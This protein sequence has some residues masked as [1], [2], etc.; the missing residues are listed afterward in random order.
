M[1]ALMA[2]T[3]GWWRRN[4][5]A[6]G[7]VAVLLPATVGGAAWWG[8]KHAYPDS[9]MPLWP[10]TPGVSGTVDLKGATWGPVKA[11]VITDTSGLDMPTGATLIGVTVEVTPHGDKGPNCFAP[12]LVEQSTGRSWQ[13]V[14][15]ELGL[16]WSTDEP[17]GC[18]P[19]LEGEKAEPYKLVLPYVV[20][21][22]AEGPFWVDIDPG[23]A[24]SKFVR[25]PIDP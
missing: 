12:E 5:L 3:R 9:G 13:S 7:A 24:E 10:V 15:G 17:E 20:P 22:D 19:T 6:L 8:W 25:L 14:R 4:T 16:S 18:V 1:G 11:K 21:E 23:Q 2:G